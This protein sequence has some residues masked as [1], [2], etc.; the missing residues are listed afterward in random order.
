[1]ASDSSPPQAPRAFYANLLIVGHNAFEFLLDF[2][3]AYSSEVPDAS[4]V[5]IVT[6]PVYAKAMLRTLQ[7]SV[8]HYETKYGAIPC[9]DEPH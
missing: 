9:D 1:M 3:Q 2:K 4:V 5:R 6:G 7:E 8:A